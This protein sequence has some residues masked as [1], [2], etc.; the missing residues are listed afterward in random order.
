[1]I[2]DLCFH[3]LYWSNADPG[4]VATHQRMMRHFG[5]PIHY[6]SEDTN[7]GEWMDQICD[8]SGSD[9]I[10]F[11]DIDCVPLDYDRV[12][13]CATYVAETQTFLGIAQCAN[14]IAPAAHIYAGPAFF[15]MHRKCWTQLRA[16]GASCTDAKTWDVAEHVSYTA[17]RL[18]ISYRCLYPD[19]FERGGYSRTAPWRLGNYGMYGI[20]T[21]YND[22]V[23]H[24]F[25]SRHRKNIA[26]FAERCDQILHGTFSTLGQQDA[27][28]FARL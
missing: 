22:T 20:G 18:E 13:R 2:P 9:V 10:G 23:Y 8:R 19:T 21:T 25:E 24:L 16:A 17:E 27:R 4:L 15:L 3:T 5:F 12:L 11:F 26:L 1:M 28:A 14:H 6:T 7:H